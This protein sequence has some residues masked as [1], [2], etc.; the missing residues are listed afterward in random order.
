MLVQ[1]WGRRGK[2]A[3][4]WCQGG[5]AGAGG[6][7]V[8]WGRGGLCP[9]SLCSRLVVPLVPF[10]QREEVDGAEHACTDPCGGWTGEAQGPVGNRL[11][12][13]VGHQ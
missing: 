4:G 12:R 7:W 2:L 6:A 9:V 11:P 8:S 3:A 13:L 5:G 10:A 1:G